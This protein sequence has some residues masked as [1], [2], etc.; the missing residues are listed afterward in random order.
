MVGND[1]DEG[2]VESEGDEIGR[3]SGSSRPAKNE[4]RGHHFLVR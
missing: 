1:Y 2:W 4:H 3:K